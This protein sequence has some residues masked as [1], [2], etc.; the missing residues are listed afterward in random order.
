MTNYKLFGQPERDFK[1]LQKRYR[2]LGGDLER[3]CKFTLK[4]EK[5]SGFPSSNKN[6]ALLQQTGSLSVFKARMACASLHGNKFRIVYA[7]HEASIEIIV[8]ELYTKI[9]KEREDQIFVTSMHCYSQKGQNFRKLLAFLPIKKNDYRV[10][11]Q[12]GI[13]SF[14]KHAS[15]K[16]SNI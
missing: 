7:R 14:S 15:N 5:E 16:R 4:L 10:K 12:N 6:Y 11:A 1:Q 2:S 9:Q 13:S 8:I 3:F